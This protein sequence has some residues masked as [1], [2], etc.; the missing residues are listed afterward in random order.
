MAPKRVPEHRT[1]RRRT[2]GGRLLSAELIIDTALRLIELHGPDGLSLRRLGAALG[3]D[4]TAIYRYFTGKDDLL[5]AITDELIGRTFAGHRTTG[6]CVADLRA[7]GERIYRANLAHPRAAAL[8]T[9]RVTGREHETAA[10]ETILGILR[11]AGFPPAEAVRHYRCFIGIALSFAALDA[12]VH[13]A[14]QAEDAIWREVYATLPAQRYPNITASAAE[15]V[16]Q[17]RESP[18]QMAMDAF[19]STLAAELPTSAPGPGGS[20]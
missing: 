18:F 20:A 3:A 5:L 7:L 1:R 14:E 13:T 16:I 15:L 17:M 4:A 19:L 10:V 9:A 2:Q 12:A 8:V 11:E 6:D